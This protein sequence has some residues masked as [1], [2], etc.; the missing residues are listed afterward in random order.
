MGAFKQGLLLGGARVVAPL[1]P[2]AES[3]EAPRASTHHRRA[4]YSQDEID[5]AYVKL[6]TGPKATRPRWKTIR[7][8]ILQVKNGIK[9]IGSGR[10][11]SYRR[12]KCNAV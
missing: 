10:N 5:A 7:R 1:L 11:I 9:V 6:M 8:T 4:G 12:K 2:K 3:V